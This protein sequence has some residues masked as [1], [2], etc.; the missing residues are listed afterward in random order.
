MI[1]LWFS[2]NL[3]WFFFYIS[4]LTFVTSEFKILLFTDKNLL[5]IPKIT[6]SYLNYNP[7]FMT[8]VN[9]NAAHNSQTKN[10][11]NSLLRI[12]WVGQLIKEIL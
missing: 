10:L 9:Y 6:D 11:K 7:Q 8:T 1:K 3:A 12:W 2:E 5:R 4:D